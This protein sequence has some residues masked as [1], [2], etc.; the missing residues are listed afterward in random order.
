M[1]EEIEIQLPV[2]VIVGRPNVGKSTL[3]NRV[4]G[5]QAAIV[6]DRPGVTRDRKELEANWLGHRFML[7]DTGGWMPGGSELDAKVSRQVE[8]A[9]RN[10]D[11]VI[12]VVDGSVGVTDDDELMAGWLRKSAATVMLVVNKADND[13]R[14]ADRWDFLSLG[15][16]DPYPVSALHGRRA[17]DLLDEVIVR[18]PSSPLSEEYIPNYGL[19]QEI[20]PVGE[21]KPP[22]VALVGRPNVGKSTL[23]NRLVGEDRAVVH[24][25]PGTTR[26]SID[27]LVE[28]EDGPV[29]FVDTAGMRRRSRIDDSAEYYSLV[30][31]LRAVDGSDIALFVIDATQGITAQDQRLAERI[32]A[33][34]C[35]IVIMLNKWELIDD[36]EERERIDLEV[37]RKLYFVDDAP[38]LKVS[39]LTGKG[40]HKL[41]PVLQE[42]ILQYHRRIPTRDV[43]RVIADAQQRHAA[44][45]GARV[46][47]ALQGATDP[48]T[49]TLFVNRELPHTYLRYLERS[50]REAF[51]FGSTPLKLRVRKRAD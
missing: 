31:A 32:D 34:G 11:L 40:V 42:A 8:A 46:M 3:F 33:A 19:D 16:G 29:V 41:R 28:T 4:I 30:R 1:S 23:F 38:V 49:F 22:R 36:A 51:N 9:V 17:G 5:E 47:Y 44:G 26:D 39:A 21:Q 15:L 43:N 27:T 18:M 24:D 35:P 50:I 10:A 12:F 6:E 13:R 2:A 7:V 48:P 25:M 20:I 37:K 45:G 14:E